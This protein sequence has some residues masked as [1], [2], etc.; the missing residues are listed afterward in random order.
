M[1][2]STS[3]RHQVP[4]LSDIIQKCLFIALGKTLELEWN[5]WKTQKCFKRPSGRSHRSYAVDL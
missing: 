5:T 3:A 2:F 1:K 4:V